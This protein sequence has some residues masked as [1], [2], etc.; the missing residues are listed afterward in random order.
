MSEV[1]KSY[2]KSVRPVFI[3]GLM[4]SG[5]TLLRALLGQ[6]PQLF[7]TFETH[8]YEDSVRSGWADSGSERMGL[9]QSLLELDDGELAR[10]CEAKRSEPQREFIDIVMAYCCERAG[11]RRWVEKTPGNIGHWQLIRQIWPEATLIHVTREYKDIYA[12]WKTRRGDSL[13]TFI[14]A[15][16]RSYDD[17]RPL[18]GHR[19]D[20]YREV[21]YVELVE[22]TEHTMR[23]VLADIGMEWDEGCG[24]IDTGE[25]ERER[26]LF[27]ELMGRESWTLVS[28]SKPIF[29][30]SIGQWRDRISAAES[31]R[32]E[33]E[34][35]EYYEIFGERWKRGNASQTP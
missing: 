2:G 19:V 20:G 34:L 7:A 26:R 24:A 9:L 12:S 27:K 33:T 8:W 3:G 14:D 25:G 28:L 18:L 4:K 6:H 31:Q 29:T 5:T 11:K 16:K 15:A 1:D 23:G 21:D 13:E 35:G 10:L 17:I 32:I 22:N 30:D